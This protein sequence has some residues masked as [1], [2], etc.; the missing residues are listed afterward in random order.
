MLGW[1]KRL[2]SL[3]QGPSSPAPPAADEMPFSPGGP[4]AY[5]PPITSW[6]RAGGGVLGDRY[7][8][9]QYDSLKAAGRVEYT[10]LTVVVDR[11]TGFPAL[12][13]AAEVNQM[14]G[15]LGGGSHALGVFDVNGHTTLGFSDDWAGASKFFPKA[16][17]VA[18]ER[19]GL[20]PAARVVLPRNPKG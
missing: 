13:V 20:D 18:V 8:L 10:Y 12:F 1:L 16:V 11:S 17:E 2:F 9:L 14:A 15:V 5:Q 3:P 6:R 4:I 19:F 7:A